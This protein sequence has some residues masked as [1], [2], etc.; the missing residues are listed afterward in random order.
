MIVSR[1][2]LMKL[3][4][5]TLSVFILTLSTSARDDATVSGLFKGNGKEAKIAFVSVKNGERDR[6]G[7]IILTFS[8]KD[9]AKEKEPDVAAM[10][11]RLGSALI[12]TLKPD[13]KITGCHVSHS[14]CAQGG[15]DSLGEIEMKDFKLADGKIQGKLTTGG[16]QKAFGETW[17]VNLTFN[18]KAP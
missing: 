1:P 6:K 4:L 3:I 18:A 10:F 11:G 14:A 8:E 13:G 15:F 17:E 7:R 16:E 2:L 12:I 5:A 9:P